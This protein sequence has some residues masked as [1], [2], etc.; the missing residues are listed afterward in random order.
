MVIPALEAT[1]LEIV[2]A[3]EQRVVRFAQRPITFAM[4]LELA[5]DCHIELVDGVMV[6]KMAVQLEHEKL[7]AWLFHLSGLYV[8]ERDLGIIPGSRTAVEISAFRGRLP[9][10]L[11]VRRERLHIVQQ[12]AISGAPDL[13]IELIS[14]HDRPSDIIALETDYRAIGVPE[15]VFID[16][17]KQR[18]RVLH[19]R[20]TAYEETELTADLLRFESLEGFALPVEWLFQDP[21]PTVRATLTEL[22]PNA[23]A[24]P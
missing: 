9:D 11:F 16:Q 2:E 13:V 12:K 10:L 3:E 18:V 8:E 19:K 22:L 5:G 14:P 21:R 7:F 23:P 15:I 17:Q 24:T 6:E 20:D 4:F 1:E